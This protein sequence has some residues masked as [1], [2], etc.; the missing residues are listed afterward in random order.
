MRHNVVIG[1]DLTGAL[2]TGVHFAS[3]GAATRVVRYHS[4]LAGSLLAR[5]HFSAETGAGAAAAGAAAGGAAP[6]RGA[7]PECAVTVVDLATRHLSPALAGER[8]RTVVREAREDSAQEGAGE[9]RFYKKT[10]STLRGNI[11]SELEALLHE[12]EADVVCF[13]PAHPA[14]GRTTVNGDQMVDGH[15]IHSTDFFRD[16]RNPVESSS[17]VEI[18]SQQASV[19]TQLV[20]IDQVHAGAPLAARPRRIAICDAE[21]VADLRAIRDWLKTQKVRYQAAGCGGFAS[22]L[23]DVWELPSYGAGPGAGAAERGS[24]GPCPAGPRPGHPPHTFEAPA[25]P[26]AG[27]AT[28]ES[29]ELGD[30]V[31]RGMLVVCGSRHARSREQVSAASSAEAFTSLGPEND[32]FAIISSSPEDSGD[33]DSVARNLAHEVFERMR[34]SPPAVLGVFGGD[35]AAAVLDALEVRV[36]RP[37][38]EFEAGV[39]G[40]AIESRPLPETRLLITKA[41]GFGS[42]ELLIRVR[43]H[44]N[45]I[46]ERGYRWLQQ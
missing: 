23:P 32:G 34:R 5:K 24:A 36:I 22:Q 33:P 9:P 17:V 39:V 29:S 1:D 30:A 31:A 19:P 13:V 11:G 20:S 26:A 27:A 2:D 7:A 43:N 6:A 38:F 28:T 21:S 46:V 3:H 44:F 45:A 16:V 40:S 12:A 18:I 35:T 41:G 10:D 4:R 15:P 42:P 14:L 37:L 8:V 25:E